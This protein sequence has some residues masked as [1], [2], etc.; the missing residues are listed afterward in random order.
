MEA[1]SQRLLRSFQ[2][3]QEGMMLVRQ[4]SE[5]LHRRAHS[6]EP[7]D[8]DAAGREFRSRLTVSA[9]LLLLG[10]VLACVCQLHVQCL[11]EPGETD[12]S[13]WVGS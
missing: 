3:L 13:V 7:L 6:G 2:A 4:E 9:V 10:L 11:G 5:A 1:P 12:S 8:V